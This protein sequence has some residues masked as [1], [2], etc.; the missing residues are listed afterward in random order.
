MTVFLANRS[1]L[2]ARRLHERIGHRLESACSRVQRRIAQP[3]EPGLYR[4]VGEVHARS[5]LDD[6]A[7]PAEAARIEIGFQLQTD[8][9]QEYYWVNWVE[10]ERE[11]LVGWHQD[12]THDSLGPVHVQVDDGTT[13]VDRRP[14][15]FVDS[16]PLDVLDRRLASLPDAVAAVEWTDGRPTGIDP[17]SPVVR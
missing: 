11:L 17:A 5:F 12:G 16:H 14:A 6:E 15:R 7:Y 10:P 4:V 13:A 8:G 2:Q 1:N 3:G 9:A